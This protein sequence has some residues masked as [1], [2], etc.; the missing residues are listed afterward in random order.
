[1]LSKLQC[2]TWS[3]I[4]GTS[5][6]REEDTSDVFLILLCMSGVHSCVKWKNN[7]VSNDYFKFLTKK[8]FYFQEVAT[9][10]HVMENEKNILFTCCSFIYVPFFSFPLFTLTGIIP[11]VF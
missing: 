4:S 6:D 11:V 5:S 2:G 10:K 8:W 3:S 1:M 7:E 9:T